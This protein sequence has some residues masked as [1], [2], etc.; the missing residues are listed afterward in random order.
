MS[1]LCMGEALIDLV[2]QPDGSIRPQPGGGPWNTALA[3]GR[4][5]VA[6]RFAWPI[7]RDR[8]G[9][10]LLDP[11]AAAGVDVSLCPRSD[12]PT[13]LARIDLNSG[14]ASY[15]FDDENSA[16]RLF[17]PDELPPL[18][19]DCRAL[20]IGGI[21][22]AAEPC[23][24][25]VELFATSA[26][27]R[28]IPLLLDPNIRPQAIQ[29]EPKYRARLDRLFA[30]SHLVKLSA[31]DAAWL[32]PGMAPEETARR[33]L[34]RGPGIVV[35]TC[36]AQGALALTRCHR[37]HAAAVPAT[38]ADSIG[39]GDS[40]NAGFLASLLRSNALDAPDS[41]A[42]TAALALATKAAAIT[43]SRPGADPPWADE[44]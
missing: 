28:G 34:A 42:L 13:A 37:L 19:P 40:F 18:S 9:R 27:R 43:V 20:V 10:L 4:L 26:A 36:G 33:I 7:S 5:G 2:P 25:T 29:N 23:G 41:A 11:L 30:L 38:M 14:D 35:L 6:T 17:S 3:L 24:S 39:A 16:G 22:L 12:R 1:V 15:R 44:L 32:A 8:Y 21:S 31:E